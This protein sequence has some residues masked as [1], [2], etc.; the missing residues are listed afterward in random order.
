M[1]NGVAYM[2]LYFGTAG[3]DPPEQPT[4][5]RK[6]PYVPPNRESADQKQPIPNVAVSNGVLTW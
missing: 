1:R 3:F 4:L 2:S 5:V 6:T